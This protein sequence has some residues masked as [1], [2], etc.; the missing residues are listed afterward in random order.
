MASSPTC[1]KRLLT[2][3]SSPS[4]KRHRTDLTLEK[5]V[6]L[7][8]DSEKLPKLSQK[9]LSLKYGIGRAT[10]SDI[11]KR[12]EQYNSQFKENCESKK[13]RFPSSSKYGELNEAVFK[14][15]SQARA[16]NIPLSGLIVHEKAL[17]FS[18]EL[19]LEEFKAS[20]GWLESWKNRYSIG[21]FKVCGE[22]ADVDIESVNDY[23]RRVPSIVAG[24]H[25]KDI[26]NCDET[27]L[28]FRALPDKTLA[29]KRKECKGGKLAKERLTVMMCC[30]SVGEKLKPLVIGKARKPRCFGNINV[31]KLPVL[32]RSN[33]KSWMTSETFKDWIGRINSDMKKQR[34][35]I[36]VFLDNAT[37]HSHDLTFS[38]VTLRYLP[39]NTTSKLQPLDLGI[40]RAFK[41]RY[42]KNMMQHLV[43][44]I[45]K[46]KHAS[47]LTKAV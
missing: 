20:N 11:L 28:F 29:E 37:S 15:F 44:N 39:A 31:D 1:K 17:Q 19:N 24:Y 43:M 40:I 12:R 23:K 14:W 10:V 21:Y 38:N 47:E 13:K 35:H 4:P 16:K 3:T 33:K 2:D 5:K 42:R 46:C 36:L 8:A 27:G 22:S 32:W 26:F 9:E 41:A 30:S 18:K 45:E 7:I 6:Q 34:R 25:N